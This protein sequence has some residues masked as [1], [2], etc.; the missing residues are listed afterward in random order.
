MPVPENPEDAIRLYWKTWQPV[1]GLPYSSVRFEEK[2]IGYNVS[3]ETFLTALANPKSVLYTRNLTGRGPRM[4]SWY[5]SV[6][7]AYVGYAL[8]LTN[9]RVCSLWDIYGD[10]THV[11]DADSQQVQLCDILRNEKHVGM[12]TGVGRNAGGDVVTIT[13][14]ECMPPKVVVAEYT[15]EEFERCW[16]DKYSVYRYNHI[17]RVTYTPSP[18]VHLEGDPDLDA[19]PINR[20]LLPDYGDKANYR[21]G[22]PVELNIMDSGWDKLVISTEDG[23]VVH[24][25]DIKEPGVISWTPEETG[26]YRAWCVRNIEVSPAVE[27]CMTSFTTTAEMT[28]DGFTLRFNIGK[29]SEI[30]SCQVSNAADNSTVSI[31]VLT[32]EENAARCCAFPTRDPGTYTIK[33]ISRNRFGQYSSK[34]MLVTVE[35]WQQR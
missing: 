34:P 27:F 20:V 31:H 35:A 12:V 24:E 9:R 13:V 26:F 8:D 1:H 25:A 23:T 21:L 11:P 2:F 19:P 4:S 14:S 16:L 15:V 17:D 18:Y 33:A 32:P 3:L 22:E 10:M 29:D 28:G 30:L 7:S 5:G 6:C